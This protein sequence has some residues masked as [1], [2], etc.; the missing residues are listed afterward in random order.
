MADEGD[1]LLRRPQRR[2]QQRGDGGRWALEEEEDAFL[3]GPE[4][5]RRRAFVYVYKMRCWLKRATLGC[6]VRQLCQVSKP[7]WPNNNAVVVVHLLLDGFCVPPLG[8]AHWLQSSGLSI[9]L[10]RGVS[11]QACQGRIFYPKKPVHE[12][13]CSG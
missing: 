8:Q 9:C 1:A 4:F 2:Q 7:T 13:H 12:R 6:P 11:T 5:P 10:Q 3:E